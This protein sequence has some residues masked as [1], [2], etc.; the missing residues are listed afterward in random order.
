MG[1]AK[2]VIEEIE[3]LPTSD[4]PGRRVS[5]S[6]HQERSDTAATLNSGSISLSTM[7]IYRKSN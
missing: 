7:D 4:P 6:R 5:D 1:C 2:Q 3:V